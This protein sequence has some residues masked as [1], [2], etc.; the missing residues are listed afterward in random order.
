MSSTDATTGKGPATERRSIAFLGGTGPLGRGLVV[1]LA[2]AGHRCII[3]SRDAGRAADAAKEIQDIVSGSI[4]G[5]TNAE[6][7]EDADI[8]VVSVPYDAMA[9]TLSAVAD[10]I[11]DKVVISCVNALAF[12]ASGPVPRR[13]DAGSAAEE[14]QQLLPRA[15]VVGAFHHLSAVTL[16]KQEQ[17]LACDVLIT[18][19]DKDANA[20]VADLVDDLGG[21]QAIHAGP[22]RLTQPVED[23]TAVLIAI[24]KRYK[25]HAGV[26]V[27]D[28]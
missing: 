16:L 11:G 23:M 1:R 19:D 3:G 22:L 12:D 10:A 24:N 4:E 26:K 18:G 14:C 2:A 6:A 27:T 7:V 25:A 28:L 20:L 8:V 13:L 21:S 5:A 9:P 15:R 17:S